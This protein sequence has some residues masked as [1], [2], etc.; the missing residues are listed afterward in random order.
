MNI[1]NFST[2]RVSGG[3]DSGGGALGYVPD[4]SKAVK[5]ETSTYTA[6]AD[7]VIYAYS[8]TIDSIAMLAPPNY[9]YAAIKK[10]SVATSF[11]NMGG[12]FVPFSARRM[13]ALNYSAAQVIPAKGSITLTS[14]GCAFARDE[15]S[16]NG[17]SFM[18]LGFVFISA[19]VGFYNGSASGYNVI[20]IPVK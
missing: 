1:H 10:G 14:D 6:P 15:I 20:F 9:P 18:A 2:L 8:C 19:G 3:A 5:V 12:V 7:G 13:G 11:A 16:V 17:V 4:W